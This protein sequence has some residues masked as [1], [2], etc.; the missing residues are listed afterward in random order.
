[1]FDPTGVF[2]PGRIVDT[3]PI[4][5]HLRFGAGYDTPDPVTNF[6]FSGNGG[7]GRAV[8]M[9]SGVGMCRKKQDGTMCP[10]FMVTQEEAHST[11][12]RANVLRLAMSGRL[13]DAGLG[14]EGVREV[15]DLCLECRACKAECPVGVDVA[16]FKSEFLADYYRRHG[17][18]LKARA[19][20]HIHTMSAWASR[21]AP[22]ANAVLRSAAGRWI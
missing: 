15:L 5:S 20:G 10:S 3:P 1:T 6:D 4:T 2:N 8:E 7:F 12:G 11:R 9:C 18:P 21:V 17:T 14:D 13:G 16:R 19:I 22:L